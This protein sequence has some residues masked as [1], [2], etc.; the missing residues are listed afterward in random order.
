[1]NRQV[2]V[3]LDAKTSKRIFELA[4][5]QQDE[6]EVPDDYD[7]V[8]V[9]RRAALSRPRAQKMDIDDDDDDDDED[10]EDVEEV[11]DVEEI[12]VSTVPFT[13]RACN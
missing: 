2:K 13:H 3:I 5:E 8:A 4:K 7:D 1:L 9:E 11:E 12:F 10:L 6:F